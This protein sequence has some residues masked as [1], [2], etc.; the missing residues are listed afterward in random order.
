M[1]RRR[2]TLLAAF[3]AVN[4]GS[5]DGIMDCWNPGGTYDNPMVGS[6][7]TGYDAVRVCMVNLV[8]GLAKTGQ[9]LTV[10]RVTEGD[11]HVMAEWHVEPPDGRRGLHVAEFDPEDRLMHV[12]VYPRT[13]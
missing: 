5:P 12:T 6:A 1:S 9:T 8:D 4:A 10:D 13:S 3:E 7:Q 11:N 2:D